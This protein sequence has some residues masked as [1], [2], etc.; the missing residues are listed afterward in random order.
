MLNQWIEN[1]EANRSGSFYSDA[2]FSLVQ[3]GQYELSFLS[4]EK[5]RVQIEEPITNGFLTYTDSKNLTSLGDSTWGGATASGAI[6]E[7]GEWAMMLAGFG[8]VGFFPPIAFCVTI[9]RIVGMLKRSTSLYRSEATKILT[10]QQ[11][12]CIGIIGLGTMGT[13]MARSLVQA[14]H[15]VV[16]YDPLPAARRR[17]RQSGGQ[18]LASASEVAQHADALICS[19]PSSAAL[20]EVV[21]NLQL[22]DKPSKK[23]MVIETST[24]PLADKLA[25]ATALRTQG[26]LML[27][28]P[29][30]GTAT[31]APEKNWIIYLSGPPAA[32]REA[33]TLVKAFTFQAP[34]VGALGA[35][36]KLKL[37]ANHLVAIYNVAYAEMVT[38]C[39]NMGLDPSMAL[40]QMGHS[41]YI[42]TGAMR[43]RVPMMI[44]R[45]YEPA[46]MKIALWQKDMQII[47]EMARSVHSP[48]P[49]LDACASVYSAAMA[50][51]LG[52]ADTAATAEVL[53]R[54]SRG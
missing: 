17:L 47:T 34:R 18:A 22:T 19:L 2:P 24:L 31:P 3:G 14:G 23:Q 54:S 8:V 51:G 4:R 15:E 32:C 42:G 11:P 53:A 39:R 35:G 12:Q 46:S 52:E 9:L 41:P 45:Q 21:A 37:A 49:L 20:H 16:G 29:I 28:A 48:T 44:E 40:A 43:L 5:V 1:I 13:I 38:L 25:A 26:R 27:D 6:P 30:S 50:L 36:M 7:P 33:A 10:K